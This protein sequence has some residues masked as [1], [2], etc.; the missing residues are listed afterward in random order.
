MK[1]RRARPVPLRP[2]RRGPVS[3]DEPS[4]SPVTRPVAPG[5]QLLLGEGPSLRMGGI[6]AVLVLDGELHLLTCGH[7]FA[8]D[9]TDVTCR[10]ATGPIAVLRRSYLRTAAP[11]D[12]AVCQLTPEGKSLLGASIDAPT[13]LRGHCE[14]TPELRAFTADFW[15]THE[16]GSVPLSLTIS[17]HAA[18]NG[19]LFPAGPTDGFIEVGGGVI[20][21]DS[22]SL[23]A[24]DSLYLGLCSGHVQG[25]WS[26]FTP[27]A[28]ALDRVC[29]EHE[30]VAIWHPDI[31]I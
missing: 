4:R 9:D 31:G 29:G 7:L 14:P 27:F 11:L 19:V 1:R 2:G 16:P 5:A 24:V 6:A 8:D 21:G 23:L 26:Y 22:G 20:P 12:A 28:A 25:T 10:D 17:A 3:F 30:E 13:W 15:P 18:S